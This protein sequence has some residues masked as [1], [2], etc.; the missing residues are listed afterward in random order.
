MST[1]LENLEEIEALFLLNKYDNN[2]VSKLLTKLQNYK[3]L[4]EY[5]Q[6][7]SLIISSQMS[8]TKQ[9]L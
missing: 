2:L 5:R 9:Q 1:L 4:P 6:Y 7:V 8:L 3:G